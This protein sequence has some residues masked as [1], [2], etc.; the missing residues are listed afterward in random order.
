[1]IDVIA[2]RS[3]AEFQV[4][5]RATGATDSRAGRPAAIVDG[6]TLRVG[7]IVG[8]GLFWAGVITALVV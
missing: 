6:R 1:M 4:R 3:S 5:R 8:C 2:V 7:A